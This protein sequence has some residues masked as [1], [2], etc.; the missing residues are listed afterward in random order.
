M[1]ISVIS[2]LHLDMTPEHPV[3]PGGE[4]LIIAGDLSEARNFKKFTDAELDTFR[5]TPFLN[6]STKQKVGLFLVDQCSKKY[7][8]IIYVAGNHEHYRNTYH[9]TFQ[10]IKDNI[11]DNFHFLENDTFT[12]GDT[13]FIGATTWTDMNKGD[14]LTRQHLKFGMNDFICVRRLVNGNYIKFSPAD[15]EAIHY[16]TMQYFKTV[17]ELPT[18]IDK[19][20]VV[21]SHHA[22]TGMSIAPEFCA[23]YLMNGG[24]YSRL[25]DFILDHP[26]INLWVCGHMHHRYRYYVGDTL[27]VCNPYGYHSMSYDEKTGWNPN[28]IVNLDA[29]P[30][31]E[32][33]DDDYNWLNP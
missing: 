9:K 27:V 31:H 24:F 15:A 29:M 5:A 25:D 4:V 16:Q 11:P 10:N 8:H 22:P 19:K 2:D 33:V 26:R 17:L 12:L 28:T 23:D 3:L 14:P 21:I 18:L 6:L 1:D 32:E 20:V 7:E 13:V 30:T